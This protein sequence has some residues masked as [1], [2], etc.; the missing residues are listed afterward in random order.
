MDS[1]DC[2]THSTAWCGRFV[3]VDVAD[4][5][6]ELPLMDDCDM[7]LKEYAADMFY[8]EKPVKKTALPNKIYA[9]EF[10]SKIIKQPFS[11]GFKRGS[12]V[13]AIKRR[14]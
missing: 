4:L 10:K 11:N 1:T 3:W 6:A 5:P 13:C 9:K 7:R 14:N 12:K 2:G 8:P